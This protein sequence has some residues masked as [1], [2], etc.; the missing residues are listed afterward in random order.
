MVKR[1]SCSCSAA[2][3]CTSEK[4]AWPMVLARAYMSR[5]TCVGRAGGGDDDENAA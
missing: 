2:K 5:H 3:F 1:V 4:V